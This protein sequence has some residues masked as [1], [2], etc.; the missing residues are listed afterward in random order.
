MAD[1]KL[2]SIRKDLVEKGEKVPV[3]DKYYGGKEP[4]E[5]KWEGDDFF[6]KLD[7][8]W[9]KAESVDWE[10]EK[11]GKAGEMYF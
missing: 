1:K 10:F 5:Y 3:G 6:V 11:G 9:L 2:A 7:G 4:L 8:K